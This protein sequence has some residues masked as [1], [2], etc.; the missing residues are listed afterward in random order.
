MKN[1]DLKK[2]HENGLKEPVYSFVP[3]IGISQI[4]EL[5]NNFSK[6]WQDNFLVSSMKADQF[7]ELNFLKTTKNYN[8]GKIRVGK[9]IRDIEY[10]Q[11]SNKIFL[12]LEDNSASIGIIGSKN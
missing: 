8:L 11:E 2:P 6:K 9:R 10:D 5:P 1:I 7:T 12:A 3:S 4:I